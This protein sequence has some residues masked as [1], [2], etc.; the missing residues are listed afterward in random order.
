MRYLV[1]ELGPETFRSELQARTDFELRPSGESLTRRYRGDHVGVHAEHDDGRFYVGC[2]V[3]GG[4]ISGKELMELADIAEHYGDGGVRLATDQNFVL[5]GVSGDVVATLLDEPLITRYS[6]TP[7]PFTRGVVACTGTEFCRF[8]I[9]ETK[10]NAVVWAKELDDRYAESLARAGK[11]AHDDEVI[12]LHFSGCSASCAQPQ[13]ADIGFRGDT[14]HRG[15]EIV[16]AVDVALGGSLG[17]DGA[18]AKWVIG[19]LPDDAVVETVSNVVDAF[20]AERRPEER[21]HAWVRRNNA[22]E[23]ARKALSMAGS[24]RK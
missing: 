18:F 9:V 19:A 16:A 4:R 17:T 1:Q 8:A 12:R 21:F 3:P 20:L 10:E 2:S 13:I 7:G 15:E 24:Y 23:V 6:P 11:P 22:E 14:A 5:T